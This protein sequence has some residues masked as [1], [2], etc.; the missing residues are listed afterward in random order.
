MNGG[1]CGVSPLEEVGRNEV[2]PKG[3]AFPSLCFNVLY[4]A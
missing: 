1:R 4:G 2:R 3:K